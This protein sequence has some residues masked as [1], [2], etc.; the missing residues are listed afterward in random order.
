MKTPQKILSLALAA[1]LSL[2]VFAGCSS[3]EDSSSS[4]NSPSSQTQQ[5]TVRLAALKGPTTMGLVKLL[6]DNEA[7]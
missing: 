3:N 7:G 1:V 4:S 5:A 6:E 2:S